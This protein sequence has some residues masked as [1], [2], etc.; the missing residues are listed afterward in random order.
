[1]FFALV[2]PKPGRFHEMGR[3]LLRSLLRA[4]V[5][6]AVCLLAAWYTVQFL[7][8]PPAFM[9]R[10]PEITRETAGWVEVHKPFRLYE[11]TSP[12]FGSGSENYTARRHAG[13]GGRIDVLQLGSISGTGPWARTE[14]YR[15]GREN[16][17][18]APLYNDMARQASRAGFAILRYSRPEMLKT[19]FGALEYVDLVLAGD[20][21]EPACAGYRLRADN[22]GF[23]IT[24]VACGGGLKPLDRQALVCAL[25]RISLVS[26]GEDR[27][28]G[29][30]FAASELRRNE[31]CT[32]ARLLARPAA[33]PARK[34]AKPLWFEQ[35]EANPLLKGSVTGLRSSQ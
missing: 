23:S 4:L 31:T 2:S 27:A 32:D 21:R 14:I 3:E 20:G 17:G 34:P 10:R 11:Q 1:M 29:Q 12:Y 24:G 22:P 25:D 5:W 19:R 15:F 28:M 16:A 9:L 6:L 35:P 18:R 30:F 8:D 13:G 33:R 26:A 7:L